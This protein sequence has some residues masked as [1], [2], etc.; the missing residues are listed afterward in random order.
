MSNTL[1]NVRP[2]KATTAEI[3]S[4]V[5]NDYERPVVFDTDLNVHKA[6]NGTAWVNVD[7]NTGWGNYAD[8]QYTSGSPFALSGNVDTLLP[9][10]KLN[11]LETQKPAD[12]TTFYDGTVITGRNGD[13]ILI[14]VD[15]I[16]VPTNA[17]TSYIEFWFDI[18]GGSGTP[19][20]L[21]NLYRR[22][23]TFP[24]GQGQ[25]RPV[26]FTVAGY[27]LNTWEANGAEVYCRS[28]NTCNLYNIRYVI[29]RT[30]QGL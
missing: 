20:D 21:A 8:T 22:I 11:T 2:D 6:F 28:D 24:K 19:A 9:N 18:T 4:W 17:G 23:I 10:N 27:T 12:V 30:H 16:A 14:T 1:F 13:G 3:N 29:T 7:T 25:E 5:M 26:N 15:L